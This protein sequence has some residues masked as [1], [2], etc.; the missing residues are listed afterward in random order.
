MEQWGLN[1]GRSPPSTGSAC[2]G[3]SAVVGR[4]LGHWEGQESGRAYSPL[5]VKTCNRWKMRRSSE[6]ITW[7]NGV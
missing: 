7:R 2:A 3:P 6:V 4:W 5:A 1:E